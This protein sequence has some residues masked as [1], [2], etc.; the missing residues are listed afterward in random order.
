MEFIDILQMTIKDTVEA[1]G[2]LAVGYATV[3]QT[4]PLVL[5]VLATRLDIA[6]PVAVLTENVKRRA[7]TVQGEEVIVNPGLSAGDKVLFLRANAGQNYYV[8]SKA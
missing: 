4:S 2:P 3:R 5:T 1:M 8:I 6:E 7:T